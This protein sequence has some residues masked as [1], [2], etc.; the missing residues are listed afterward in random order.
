[1]IKNLRYFLRIYIYTQGQ[2]SANL[3]LF[4]SHPL[5]SIYKRLLLQA[6]RRDWWTRKKTTKALS[7][8]SI[9]P[10][11]LLLLL[12]TNITQ[13]QHYQHHHHNH[14][15]HHHSQHQH[16]YTKTSWTLEMI[17]TFTLI[18][19]SCYFSFSLGYCI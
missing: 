8:C 10:E 3:F 5:Y 1:M 19:Y 14:H 4:L 6:L 9:N 16:H 2:M 11:H 13:Y 17:V 15:H 18:L 7:Q 12:F